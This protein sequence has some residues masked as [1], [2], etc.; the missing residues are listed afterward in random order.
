MKSVS[1][2]QQTKKKVFRG[3]YFRDKDTSIEAK[4]QAENAEISPLLK[5]GLLKKQKEYNL[6]DKIKQNHERKKTETYYTGS[7]NINQ[8]S[9]VSP[10][11]SR[12]I[13]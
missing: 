4:K 7:L 6:I 3:A 2:K 12:S 13:A 9:Q 1:L 11:E 5:D 10:K 8:T